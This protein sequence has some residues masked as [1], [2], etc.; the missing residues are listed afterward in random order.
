MG[1]DYFDLQEAYPGGVSLGVGEAC[2]IEGAIIDKNARL[3]RGVRILP[4][5]PGTEREG[6]DWFVRD[7]I[8][9]I[10]KNTTLAPGTVIGPEA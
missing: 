6:T 10:P 8:V 3:G 4:F 2:H 9:V 7:G 5:P 1:S